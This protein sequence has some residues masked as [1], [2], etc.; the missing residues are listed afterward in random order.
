MEPIPRR[1]PM[2]PL[3]ASRHLLPPTDKQRERIAR[4]VGTNVRQA[5]EAAKISQPTLRAFKAYKR[6]GGSASFEQFKRTV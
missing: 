5:L 4:Q 6:A 3:N 2:Q 1:D